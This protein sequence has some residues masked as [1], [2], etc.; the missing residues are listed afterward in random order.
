MTARNTISRKKK[1]SQVYSTRFK[2]C[3]EDIDIAT[4]YLFGNNSPIYS[5]VHPPSLFEVE[6]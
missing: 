3:Q 4:Q 1:Q 6:G 5:K 2:K